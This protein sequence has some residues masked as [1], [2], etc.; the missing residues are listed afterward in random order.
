MGLQS[1]CQAILKEERIRVIINQKGDTLVE[2]HYQDAKILLEDVL[3]YEYTDSLLIEYKKRDSLNGKKITLQKSKIDA[4]NQKT[5]NLEE[6]VSNFENII[7]NK[8]KEIA[9]K[10]DE[11]TSLKKEVVK[12]KIL[13]VVGFSTAVI[14]SILTLLSVK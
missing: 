14:F 9:L 10:E 2:M 8:D 6:M 13:K 4:L 5:Q 11:I 7:R 12:Q 3:H 1:S